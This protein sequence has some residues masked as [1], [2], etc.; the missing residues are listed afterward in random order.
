MTTAIYLTVTLLIFVGLLFVIYH[1]IHTYRRYRGFR[2]I[3]CPE[4]QK[5]AIVEVD[6]LHA[7]LTS[8]IGL[9]DIR[10]DSCSRWPLKRECGQECL[11][12]LDELSKEDQVNSV[13]MK[14]YRG[15]HC[16]YCRQQFQSLHWLDDKPALQSPEGKLLEWQEIPR[17][18]LEE[19]LDSYLPVCWNCYLV[20]FFRL[21]YP[22]MVV[23]H[24]YCHGRSL[25]ATKLPETE[26]I[27]AGVVQ[28]QGKNEVAGT[29][30]LD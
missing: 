18:R 24:P 21:Q 12:G 5:S 16:V 1:L 3:T 11:A 13:M 15:K 26:P 6:A 4:T 28:S 23:Y 20:Q 22:G 17:E 10:L 29:P 8:T 25:T 19:A 9:T 7:A 30:A 27:P 14:W 2:R